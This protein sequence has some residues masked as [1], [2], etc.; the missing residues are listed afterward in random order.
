MG[1]LKHHV[2]PARSLERREA[3]RLGIKHATGRQPA[4]RCGWKV[5][6]IHLISIYRLLIDGSDTTSSA[7]TSIFYELANLPDVFSRLQDEIGSLLK[8]G[9]TTSNQN[10]QYLDVLNRIINETLRL[11]PPAGLLQRKT[12]PEGLTIGETYIPGDTTVFCP[13]YVAGRSKS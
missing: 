4:Y 1:T 6:L 3:H 13:L 8:P 5:T 11:H 10:L 9:E 12:P 2:F 7:L